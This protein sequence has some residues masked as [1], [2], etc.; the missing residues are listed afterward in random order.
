MKKQEISAALQ[1]MGLKKADKVLLHSS[2]LSLGQVEGGPDA[3]IDAFLDVLGSEGTLLVPVFGA[4]G[5]LTETLK[6]RPGAVISPCPVGTL[7]AIGKDAQTLCRDHWKAD[8]AHGENT[9][10][11]RLIDMDGYVCLLGVDQDR[12][13]SLHGIE[14]MLQLPY[15]EDT[16]AT[17]TTPEGETVTKTWKYY[18]GP[19]RDFIGIDRY[20]RESGVMKISRIGNSQVRLIKSRDL[21]EIGLALGSED[22]AFVLCDN[23]EC[24]DCVRQRAAV[25]S[26]R[27]DKE[28]FKL[29]ASSRLAGRYVPEMIENLQAV[30]IRFVE[31]DY[32]QGKSC[33]FM[34]EEKI[35]AAA[36][37]FRSEGIEIS[38]LSAAAVPDDAE[39]LVKL[40][41]AANISRI[42]IP[43]GAVE[44]ANVISAA[45]IEVVF[46]NFNQTALAMVKAMEGFEGR[47]ACFNPAG[48]ALAGEHPFLGSYRIG[49][50]I[51]T[52]AQLD[53]N[54]AL[55]DGTPQPLARGNGE[56]KEL[57]S[58][59][60][61]HNFAGFFSLGGGI[62][63]PVTLK[64]MAEDFVWLLDN[65]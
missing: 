65:M 33:A 37:E 29:T 24:A 23:P 63:A 32:L 46:R 62:A 11:T 21:F 15:L 5:I 31:L 54:D 50:F 34:S 64:E 60:R 30:G 14:A 57:I 47:H 44:A 40:A 19:H 43:A 20:Y 59:L 51:K 27:M 25:F 61:C 4:L 45:G 18:P 26:D 53:I 58:I 2:L 35:A 55:W 48:F 52:I 49:R 38:A 17:F 36:A 7:A 6:K 13:T 39:Q 1:E 8:T 16:T 41:K 22:P 56:I 3:V 42:I 12:N 9:P 28:S 10:F